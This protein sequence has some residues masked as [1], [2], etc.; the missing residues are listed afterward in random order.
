MTCFVNMPFV[1]RELRTSEKG[2][3]RVDY[4]ASLAGE[5]KSMFSLI[6]CPNIRTPDRGSRTGRV[7]VRLSDTAP[8]QGKGAHPA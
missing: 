4:I 8:M 2:I 3:C 5:V 7:W 1:T 6:N